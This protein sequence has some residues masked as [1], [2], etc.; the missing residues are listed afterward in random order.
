M[1]Q[2]NIH[3]SF[4]Q[5]SHPLIKS[6]FRASRVLKI[7]ITYFQGLCENAE[8]DMHLILGCIFKNSHKSIKLKHLSLT[9]RAK[10]HRGAFRKAPYNKKKNKR[11]EYR[12]TTTRKPKK[13]GKMFI[14]KHRNT[15]QK[16]LKG[17]YSNC[18]DSKFPYFPH[19]Q[20]YYAYNILVKG[21]YIWP[22]QFLPLHP[23]S[24]GHKIPTN[25]SLLNENF[26]HFF[27]LDFH[28]SKVL[29]CLV[30]FL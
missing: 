1:I 7:K 14:F 22:L 30:I 6:N 17:V 25:K 12:K 15:H 3:Q 9:M 26:S 29:L 23:K 21:I 5:G 27:T 8:H 4:K 2:N 19:C 11:F 16:G 20:S 28:P 10:Y 18:T 24:M 13:R